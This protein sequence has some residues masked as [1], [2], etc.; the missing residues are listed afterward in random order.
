[1]HT[2]QAQTEPEAAYAVHDG[3]TSGA[4]AQVPAETVSVDRRTG[5]VCV[6]ADAHGNADQDLVSEPTRQVET[7]ARGGDRETEN[8]R[9]ADVPRAAAAI[10]VARFHG[11]Q[12]AVATCR[13]YATRRPC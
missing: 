6:V 10:V 13:T 9:E 3:T 11:N 4:R 1:M 8:G 2:A 7:P 5:G 12:H